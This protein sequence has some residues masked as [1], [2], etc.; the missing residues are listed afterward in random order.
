MDPETEK[1]CQEAPHAPC[2][3]R[4]KNIVELTLHTAAENL[5]GPKLPLAV[6][7]D[8]VRSMHNVG[9]ILRTADALGLHE[10]ILAG[11]SGTPPHPEIS[12]TAL[13]AEDSVAWRHV[14]DALAEVRRLQEAG[15]KVCVLEQTHGS[16]PLHS[17]VPR[18]EDGRQPYVV[19]V[20]GNEVEGV[21]Q[22]IVDA[23]DVVLEIPQHGAKHSMNVSVSTA[24]ALWHLSLHLRPQAFD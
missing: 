1:A 4:K 12:K 3:R 11:I 19:L 21:G 9:S 5:R 17:F 2:G 18:G 13:G 16:V 23:A 6:L 10:V 7:C 22:R 24:I 14:D 8:S 15:A 20:A